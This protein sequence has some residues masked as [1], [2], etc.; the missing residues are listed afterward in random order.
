MKIALLV[1]LL[2]A[3]TMLAGC[4]ARFDERELLS[5]FE[6]KSDRF[7]QL[8]SLSLGDPAL[9]RMTQDRVA[10][11]SGVLS[12]SRISE[13]RSLFK[14]LGISKGLLRR[15]G[16]T[17]HVFFI[18]DASGLTSGGTMYGYAYCPSAVTPL[19]EK[20]DPA[21]LTR[22]GMV[23]RRISDNWFLFFSVEG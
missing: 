1:S 16:Y 9:S 6:K 19:V 5:R 22:T 12:A 7:A 18:V 11:D 14:Q 2:A 17:D 15:Y 20:I 13:Y 21:S 4:S 10:L 3:L 23:F 8:A